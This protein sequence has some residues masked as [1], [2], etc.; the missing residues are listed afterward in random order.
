MP[1]AS[2]R[3]IEVKKELSNIFKK[4]SHPMHFAKDIDL[5][6]KYKISR[7]TVCRIRGELGVLGRSERILNYLIN[8]IDT[9][10]YTLR[11][12]SKKLNIKYQNL[13]KI[14]RKNSIEVKSDVPPIESLKKYSKHRKLI[15]RRKNASKK[16]TE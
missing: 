16:T 5:A 14:V 13:Y 10:R 11:D 7:H 2:P 15:R 4:V 3:I 6:K 8:K 12:L 9:K 1:K